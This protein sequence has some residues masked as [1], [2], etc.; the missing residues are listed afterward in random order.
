MAAITFDAARQ[1]GGRFRLAAAQM[2]YARQRDRGDN[3]PDDCCANDE[4]ESTAG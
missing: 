3:R 2:K 1:A 4:R